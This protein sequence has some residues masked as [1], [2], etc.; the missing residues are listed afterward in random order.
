MDLF[1]GAVNRENASDILWV[2]DR[3]F[4]YMTDGTS[5]EVH[6][7]RFGSPLSRVMEGIRVN[8]ADGHRGGVRASTRQVGRYINGVRTRFGR[9]TARRKRCARL[10]ASV[11]SFLFLHQESSYIA[12]ICHYLENCLSTSRHF[13]STVIIVGARVSVDHEAL[14]VLYTRTVLFYIFTDADSQ[15]DHVLGFFSKATYSTHSFEYL[16]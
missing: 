12:R 8:L 11:V 3:C 14:L 7:V 15:R 6:M 13:S 10:V 5:W 9:W 4:K 1:A 16:I 2:C